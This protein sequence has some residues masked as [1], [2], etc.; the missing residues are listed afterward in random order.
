[1]KD[2]L[3]REIPLGALIIS[4]AIGRNSSGMKYGL[5][6]ETS[7]VIDEY[8]QLVSGSSNR[9]WVEF[10]IEKEIEIKSSINEAR[11]KYLE[12]QEIEKERQKSLKRILYKN[13][14][15]GYVYKNE[16]GYEYIFWG[17]AK[18]LVDDTYNDNPNNFYCYDLHGNKPNQY[19]STIK[20]V[21]EVGKFER[22]DITLTEDYCIL[23]EK[24]NFSWS[25]QNLDKVVIY[26]EGY[27]E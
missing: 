8:G 22:D 11:K 26:R 17:K 7:S 15:F 19:K 5:Q 10:P 3:G 9:Y 21:E 16:K 14:K 2:I 1:M 4:M 20:L 25:C 27:E 12:E 6:T 13:L 24:R 18:V 23:P